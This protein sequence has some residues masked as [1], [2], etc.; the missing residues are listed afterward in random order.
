M[1]SSDS[2]LLSSRLVDLGGRTRRRREAQIAA[3]ERLLAATVLRK[4]LGLSALGACVRRIRIEHRAQPA[5]PFGERGRGPP[6]AR[7]IGQLFGIGGQVE[8]LWRRANVVAV[9]PR[10]EAQHV[11]AASGCGRV[12][13]AD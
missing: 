4:E 13:F 11:R 9:L 7:E 1:T 3:G 5:L 8:Q 2:G 12:V 10:A 6:I